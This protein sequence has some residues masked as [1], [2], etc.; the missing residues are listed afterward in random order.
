M[1]HAAIVKLLGCLGLCF[2]GKMFEIV[3]TGAPFSALLRPEKQ[4]F[5][6]LVLCH[7]FY[8]LKLLTSH[9]FRKVILF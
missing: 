1:V 3:S 8:L 6:A 4:T 9:L 2:R 7:G 5:R